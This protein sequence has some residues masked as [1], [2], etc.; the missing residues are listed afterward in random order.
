MLRIPL[1][2]F[3]RASLAVEEAT[4]NEIVSP[5]VMAR[6]AIISTTCCAALGAEVVAIVVLFCFRVIVIPEGGISLIVSLATCRP[7]VRVV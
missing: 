7:V 1:N 2:E 5:A 6:V 3:G 4:T